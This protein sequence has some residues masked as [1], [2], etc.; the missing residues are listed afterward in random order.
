M[1]SVDPA[2]GLPVDLLPYAPDTAV[3]QAMIER[4]GPPAWLDEL[5]LRPGEPYVHMGTHAAPTNSWLVADDAREM[6]LTIRRRLFAE[7]RDVVFACR[8]SAE[9]AAC[10]VLADVVTWLDDRGLAYDPPDPD[11][12]PLAAAGQVVQDDLCL[13]IHRDGA[14]H[15]DGGSVCFPSVWR[16]AE[17]IGQPTVTVHER[18]PHYDSLTDRVD[19]FFDRLQPG[20][21]V[22]RRNWSLKPYPHLH[23]PAS[24]TELPEGGHHVGPNG[25]PYWLRSERQTLRRL[26]TSGAIVFAIRVQ[27]APADV[28]RRRPDVARALAALY[29]RWD[30]PMRTFKF[31]GSDLFV[32]FVDWLD[33]VGTPGDPRVRPDTG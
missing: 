8:P 24:K 2:T 1:P 22:W 14:W 20:R 6:E 28:L 29:R 11:E 18:V 23:V 9:E 26:P 21:V 5:D 32:G 7:R 27:L 4:H 16:M 30:E 31:A 12:H 25:A 19:R 13:M 33:S 3:Y 10:E 15:F 17:R